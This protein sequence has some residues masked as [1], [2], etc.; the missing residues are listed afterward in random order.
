MLTEQ[1]LA[2]VAG[3]LDSQGSIA[4]RTTAD[5]T[6]L[7]QLSVSGPNVEMLLWLGEMTGVKPVIT[8]RRYAKAGCAEHCSEKHVH[9]M[10]RSGRWLISG[11]KATVVL[12]A[13][14]P[15]LR[16]KG[17]QAG[18]AVELGLAAPFKQATPAKMRALGWPL[19]ESWA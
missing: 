4:V 16:W 14:R 3:I 18:S 6:E 13:T 2:Y 12:A 8:S 15:F 11:A 19:P 5:G 17:T 10:S 1:E 9:V 7:P